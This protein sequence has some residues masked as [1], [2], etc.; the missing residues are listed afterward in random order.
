[1]ASLRLAMVSTPAWL[2]GRM[3]FAMLLA[4]SNCLDQA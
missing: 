2:D 3:A 1:L 4:M